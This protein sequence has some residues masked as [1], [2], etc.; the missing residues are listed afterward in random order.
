VKSHSHSLH[1]RIIRAGIRVTTCRYR[2]VAVGFNHTGAIIGIA[3]NS[4]RLPMRGFHAEET[5]I[6]RS[7]RSLARILIARVGHE[8]T[9]LPID[10]CEQCQR[11]AAK[12]SIKIEAYK[13]CR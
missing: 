11:L 9:L 8:G 5:L 4:P 6:R 7:P 3:T 1:T 10:P 13:E 2:V 12:Y